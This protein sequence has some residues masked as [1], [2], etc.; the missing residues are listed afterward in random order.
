[1]KKILL[2]I[3]SV[4]LCM[5]FAGCANKIKGETHVSNRLSVLV[6][7]GWTLLESSGTE[8]S[9]IAMAKGENAS[10]GKAPTV[11]IYYYLPTQNV[12]SSKYFYE[13][14]EDLEEFD[15]AGFRY[16]PWKFEQDGIMGKVLESFGEKGSVV[17]YL[18]ECEKGKEELKLDDPEVRA[19]LESVKVTPETSADWITQREDGSL[20]VSLEGKEGYRWNSAYTMSYEDT[21][22]DYVVQD[23]RCSIVPL[24]GTG[25]YQ[26]TLRLENPEE[27]GYIGETVIGFVLKDGK[28]DYICEAVKKIFDEET[29]YDLPEEVHAEDYLG[30]W[31]NKSEEMTVQIG[32]AEDAT[33]SI[34]FETLDGVYTMNGTVDSAGDLAFDSY[35]F[36]D[37]ATT[38][39]KSGW[40]SLREGKLVLQFGID[41]LELPVEFDKAE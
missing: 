27:T 21:G 9:A 18:N 26:M 7:E 28:I 36:V 31:E 29:K 19:I 13:N 4:L 12:F 16:A 37:L 23:N 2:C 1:M 22:V 24:Y 33:L 32:Q 30:Q 38:V 10:F 17:I 40:F 6:P 5:S 8:D 20:S 41:E 14:A 3:L 34:R 35:T 11:V 15:A 39:E 25:P